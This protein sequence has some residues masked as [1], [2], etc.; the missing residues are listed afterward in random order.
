[1]AFITGLSALDKHA[2]QPL[3]DLFS[4]LT[5][6]LPSLDE[7]QKTITFAWNTWRP[8]HPGRI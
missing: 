1:M 6:T 2:S 4:D 7:T 8:F 5:A 3:G